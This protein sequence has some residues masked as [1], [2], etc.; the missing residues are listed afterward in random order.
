MPSV[1]LGAR[2]VDQLVDNLG[3]SDLELTAAEVAQLSDASAPRADDYPYGSAG[4]AQRGRNI[5]GGR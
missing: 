2:T 4:V 1:I 3:A 5:E